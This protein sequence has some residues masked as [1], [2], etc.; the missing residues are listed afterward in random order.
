MTN[1][2]N[3][4]WAP[5]GSD[6]REGVPGSSGDENMNEATKVGVRNPGYADACAKQVCLDQGTVYTV[7]NGEVRKTAE[8][9]RTMGWCHQEANHTTLHNRMSSESQ[10]KLTAA[11]GQITTALQVGEKSRF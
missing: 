6:G 1:V 7:C 9:R 11:L 3:A 10:A 2:D 5:E 4:V 8:F